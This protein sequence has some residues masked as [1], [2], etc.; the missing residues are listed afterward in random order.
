MKKI[1]LVFLMLFIVVT[2]GCRKFIASDNQNNTKGVAE[3]FEVNMPAGEAYDA[4]L[5]LLKING[6]TFESA[7][8]DTGQIISNLFDVEEGYISSIAYKTE[9]TFVGETSKRTTT[10]IISVSKWYRS[11]V[12]IMSWSREGIDSSRTK[13]L[14][15]KIKDTL[16]DTR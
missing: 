13:V 3:T 2:V 1:G 15:Q 10:M 8:K 16:K 12:K 7:S 14:S 5:R 9:I 4:V 6:Y 11:K